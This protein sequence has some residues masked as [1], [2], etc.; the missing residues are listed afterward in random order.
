MALSLRI[1]NK[2]CI[3]TQAVLCQYQKTGAY[4]LYGVHTITWM[5]E[6]MPS[7]KMSLLIVSMLPRS[8]PAMCYEDAGIIMH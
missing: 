1:C 7:C 6:L 2:S 8:G 3:Y 5:G 4:V